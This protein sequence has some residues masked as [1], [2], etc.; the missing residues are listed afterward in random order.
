[1]NS[2]PFNRIIQQSETEYR[3]C[4]TC[5]MDTTDPWITFDQRGRCNHCQQVDH[6]L[7]RW[8]PGG[9]EPALQALIERVKRDGQGREYDVVIG[10]SGGVDSSYLVYQAKQWGLRTLVIHVD[11]GWN[12]ELAVKNIQNIV[13]RSGFDLYT[14]VV[15]WEEMRD[16]Q[17]AFFKSG[18]PNQD[19]PQDHAI[20][21][22]FIRFAA[23]HDVVWA[24]NGSNLA[25]ESILPPSWGYDNMD[26]RHIHDIHRK[27]GTRPLKKF[28]RL[29]YWEN[30][31]RYQLARRLQVAKPLDLV[32]YRKAEAIAT[33]EREVEW[34]YY[35]GKHYESRFTKFFQGWYLPTKWGYDKRLAHLSSL[36]VSGQMSRDEALDEFERGSLPTAEITADRD[37]MVRKLGVTPA[38][39]DALMNV[40]NHPHSR[41]LMTSRK[42]RRLA[43]AALVI[44]RGRGREKS[45]EAVKQ[46]AQRIVHVHEID[47]LHASRDL[48]EARTALDHGVA[49]DVLL[50]GR[51]RPGLAST[52]R[53]SDSM[54]IRRLGL[55]TS[56][57]PKG[58]PFALLKMIEAHYKYLWFLKEA[59]PTI[60]HCHSLAALPAAVAAAKQTGSRI[61]Y[62]CHELETERNGLTGL[63]QK[64]DRVIESK[65]IRKCDAVITVND[66][67]AK[68]YATRYQMAPPVV[69]RN[70]PEPLA[71]SARSS[72]LLR[73]R[74]QIPPDHLIF[75][76]LGAFFT[77]RRIEQLL[78]VFKQTSADRHLV[79]MGYGPLQPAIEAAAL[80]H[81]NIHL[82]PAVPHDEVL[83]YTAG[84]DVG[85]SGGENVCLSYYYS[86]PNKLF[87]YL[88]AGLPVLVNDWPEMVS[89]VERYG[90]GWI[91]SDD[92]KSWKH[93]IDT[94]TRDDIARAQSGV[95]AAQGSLKWENEAEKLLEVYRR[96]SAG[97]RI[98]E[99]NATSAVA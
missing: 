49:D 76:Y 18:V 82:M 27:F 73:D 92:E 79:L 36:V 20:T 83:Q 23:K 15:D 44:V 78:S 70:V 12:S 48:R 39:F 98:P 1:M 10:L 30:V 68:W 14:H 52:E 47:F 7:E 88:L 87:E 54:R 72:E 38:E 43:M 86:L 34:R 96:V 91:V 77:G 51:H 29:P 94:L 17:L 61:I 66:S 31:L 71:P 74:F 19:I 22:G 53:L 9:D 85:I 6:Y 55:L 67:I 46:P 26:W 42:A 13:T 21:A 90:C 60:I 5:I 84:A 33:L 64:I 62:D 40:P 93:T 16:M 37:Y 89:L 95:K 63:A 97:S 11:T 56:R 59:R 28:P 80:Q 99:T 2:L 65:L 35:G 57:L 81:P 58:K 41:Y 50:V 32:P 8:S 4:T 3:R 45:P 69:V 24:F 75:I 25:C